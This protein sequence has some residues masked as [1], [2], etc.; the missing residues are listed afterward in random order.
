MTDPLSTQSIA[1]YLRIDCDDE[2]LQCLIDAAIASAKETT[3]FDV[4][5]GKQEDYFDARS[6]K[7]PLRSVTADW[8]L[9]RFDGS[10]WQSQEATQAGDEL[11]IAQA[12]CSC[13]CSSSCGLCSGKLRLT[14]TDKCDK[15]QA[16]FHFY[17]KEYVAYS[18][19]NRGDIDVG[20]LRGLSRILSPYTKV[21]F[22]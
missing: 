21:A 7:I 22:F 6:L 4:E 18:W 5:S 3:G 1:N 10:A 15:K 16:A 20:K 9:D 8:S 13:S 19:N 17:V 11:C 2:S 12:C 14:T